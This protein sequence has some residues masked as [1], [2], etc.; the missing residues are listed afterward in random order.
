MNLTKTPK[1]TYVCYL[2]EKII[3]QFLKEYSSICCIEKEDLKQKGYY[4]V[5][6]VNGKYFIGT[7]L[8][9]EKRDYL[10]EDNDNKYFWTLAKHTQIYKVKED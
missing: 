8:P 6:V 9:L 7:E 5:H 4:Y 1:S 2:D 10:E 3:K